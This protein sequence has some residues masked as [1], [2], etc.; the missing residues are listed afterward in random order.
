MR[1]GQE[2]SF[3]K[4]RCAG[5]YLISAAVDILSRAKRRSH[6]ERG[7]RPGHAL[8]I[9]DTVSAL[10]QRRPGHDPDAAAL[11]RQSRAEISGRNRTCDPEYCRR[12]VRRTGRPGASKR[13]SIISAAVKRRKIRF[14]RQILSQDTAASFEKRCLFHSDRR[15]TREQGRNRIRNSDIVDHVHLSHIRKKSV[16]LLI[17]LLS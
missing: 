6:K 2:G 1:R 4:E 17:P 15:R 14:C 7:F 16:A 8:K 13:E 12:C 5:T 10:R 3:L 9:D 11:F